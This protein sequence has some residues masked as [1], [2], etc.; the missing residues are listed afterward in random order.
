MASQNVHV[1]VHCPECSYQGVPNHDGHCPK[2]KPDHVTTD[3]REE[4]GE[5]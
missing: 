2:C 4:G 3:H 5:A 1:W